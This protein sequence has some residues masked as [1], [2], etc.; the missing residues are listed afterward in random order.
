MK[1]HQKNGKI[2]DFWHFFLDNYLM[3]RNFTK[4]STN[5]NFCDIDKWCISYKTIEKMVKLIIFGYLMYKNFIKAK[6]IQI[7]IFVYHIKY[8]STK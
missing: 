5:K 3:Y 7:R 4:I 6:F 8:M 1:N 2:N